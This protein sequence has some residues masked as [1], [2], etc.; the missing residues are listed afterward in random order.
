[1]YQRP[2]P[3]SPYA[4]LT[5]MD[6]LS[7]TTPLPQQAVANQDFLAP[8]PPD[9]SFV[10]PY[11]P[12]GFTS[13][14]SNIHSGYAAIQHSRAAADNALLVA[15]TINDAKESVRY[16]G[17][18]YEDFGDNVI[19]RLEDLLA[20]ITAL[21]SAS[22][23]PGFFSVIHL[24]LRTHYSKPVTKKALE[25]V[26]AAFDF[27]SE[28][29]VV[30]GDDGE[31][32]LDTQSKEETDFAPRLAQ[33][34]G[35]LQGWKDHKN[36]AFAQSL[37]TTVNILV[38]LG[39]CPDWE[40]T[41]L[42]VGTY[43]L[44]EAKAW[45][46]QKDSQTFIEV[47]LD[48]AFFWI[49]RGYSAFV[50]GDISLLLHS[51]RD[52][53]AFEQEYTL[54]ISALPILESGRLDQLNAVCEGI[55]DDSEY[56]TRLEKLI[57]NCFTRLKSEKDKYSIATLTSKLM[58]LKKARAALIMNQKESV[59][60]QKA[61]GLLLYGGSSRGKTALNTLLI[62]TL[63]HHND[64]ENSKEHV[65]VLNDNDKFQ[66][67]YRACH[68]AVTMDD[69]GNT[70][71]EHYDAAPTAKIIDFLNNVPKAALNPNVELKGNV[72]I[73][74]KIV[75]VT[76]NRK[77]LMAHLFSNEPVSIFRRFDFVLDIELKPECVDPETGGVNPALMTSVMPDVWNITLQTVRIVRQPESK[78]DS[79]EFVDVLTDAS[80]FE[81]LEYLKVASKKH[82]AQQ[83]AY[84]NQVE[85][86]Y[87]MELCEHSYD[88]SSCPLCK[89]NLETMVAES[90][91][92]AKSASLVE[93][94]DDESYFDTRK[95]EADIALTDSLF[96][97]VKRALMPSNAAFDKFEEEEQV[98]DLDTQCLL[99]PLGDFDTSDPSVLK[100]VQDSLQG[101]VPSKASKL[102][103]AFA[104]WYA[105]HNYFPERL[106]K[107][108]VCRTLQEAFEKHKAMALKATLA[109]LGI[110]TV[111]YS[112]YKL[113]SSMDSARE[114]FGQG[115]EEKAPVLLATDVANPWK[116]V[117]P[118]AIPKTEA[119][120]TTTRADL[121]S[122]VAKRMGHVTLINRVASTKL[123]C[124]IIPMKGN[125]WL[126]PSHMLLE[127]EYE[128]SVQTT[129]RDTLGLNFSQRIDPSTW[130]RLPGDYT[131]VRLVNGGPVADLSKF[132]PTADFKLTSKLFAT[133]L[134][135]ED[136]GNVNDDLVAVTAK[137]QI[138]SKAGTF[139]GISY[140]YPRPTFNGLCMAPVIAYQN[141][142]V[143]LGFHLAGKTGTPVGAAGIL[144]Q[145]EFDDGYRALS[146]HYAMDC[147]SEG[148]LLTERF[149]VDFTPVPEVEKRH[150]VKWLQ[151]DP[152]DGQQPVIE[153]LG[154]HP[155]GTARFTSHIRETPISPFV[156]EIMDMPKLHGQPSNRNIA[157]H[158]ARDV[159]LMAHPKGDFIPAIF[160]LARADFSRKVS[161]FLEENP[162]Q[163]KLVHPYPRPYVL[164]GID[165]V[166]S[167]DRIDLST[168]MGFPLNKKKSLFIEPVED[169]VP[170]L[171]E[172]V[173]FVDPMF[174]EEF[175]RMEDTLADGERVYVVHRA[176]LKD[177][178]VA[179]LKKKIRVFA[180]GECMF[181]CLV[182]K[183]Y[184]PIV[185]LLQSN[186]KHFETAVGI[187]AHGPEWDELQ[188]YLSKF[189]G[190]NMVAGDYK[191]F[192]K[193]A[194][195]MAMMASFE[196]LIG[197][198]I[199]AGYTERQIAIMRGIAT[200]ICYPLYEV[201]G[202]LLLLLGSNPSGHPLTVIINDIENSLYIRYA[203]YALHRGEK[204]IPEFDSVVSLVTYGDDNA[205]DIS[206][207]ERLLNHTSIANEL[208]KVG[209][210][211]TMA[212]KKAASI[213]YIPL[214]EISFLKRGFVI[215]PDLGTYVAPLEVASI[216]K[217]LHN[218]MM[219]K[220]SDTPPEQIAAQALISANME[221]FNHG[222]EVFEMRHEQIKLVAREAGIEVL[223]GELS[224]YNDL[225]DRYR[226]SRVRRSPLE[227]PS[228]Y[229]D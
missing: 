16:K 148:T 140:D 36:S 214:S 158:W 207:D 107:E 222:R 185:R 18:D 220:G 157:D 102:K 124:N 100:K 217:S 154:T 178:A 98:D 183:Y 20:L 91:A 29:C 58:T 202:V 73:A 228:V 89:K 112:A 56:E 210:T 146:A 28:L 160:N 159:D 94:S 67:E 193:T 117:S 35:L 194:T 200:E 111:V 37:A 212:D 127:Q 4:K 38:T 96:G 53:A 221:F 85:D 31:I 177:E 75:T 42:T 192:D 189:G 88:P 44:F 8:G 118:V 181:T 213:P 87:A 70:K 19:S 14:F 5:T 62:K 166:T 84:V 55:K 92:A 156:S 139:S 116:K 187:N 101:I 184:L 227:E 203:Y 162:E 105:A 123:G 167:V 63:L 78:T 199:A 169:E 3:I 93:E 99:E 26:L 65:I 6:S 229:L 47:I 2:P 1:M 69:Y 23:F 45:D 32:E 113:Y 12:Q 114:L 22:T 82:F 17:T 80:I 109:S 161:K 206:P 10:V 216:S 33:V 13:F 104:D 66:S 163:L 77:D 27:T 155:L 150:C 197:I 125:A 133:V 9:D 136:S 175:E 131:M 119:S 74:P 132:L 209:I 147:H 130:V 106:N 149:G 225:I 48:T 71:A 52:A 151:D 81:V 110:A 198:A 174:W 144:T 182:R 128:L 79:Y 34:K 224:T 121:V 115:S 90:I 223:V 122:K 219:H 61:L 103:Q 208:A 165:G 40:K 11:E 152:S 141:K 129:E 142:P 59:I 168:S 190:V 126:L 24:Y 43:H 120:R 153:I 204:D 83:T 108:N 50:N 46:L 172:V 72:M 39:F 186:W 57:T 21:S 195:P 179:F 86:Y 76:T 135:K 51:D 196:I 226:Q 15:R 218:Y 30:R 164:G 176:N 60:H 137:R 205:M 143:I 201:D 68:N 188:K 171:T 64:F 211:Y 138:T 173:D 49:E 134:H 7:I 170:G 97:K 145:K 54:L 191:A 95:C 41:P 25:M 215:N 180:G